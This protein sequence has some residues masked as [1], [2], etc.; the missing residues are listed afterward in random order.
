VGG[1]DS[2]IL[3]RNAKVWTGDAE[4]PGAS[5]VDIAGDRIAWVGDDA[6]ARERMGTGALEIDAAGHTVMPG[7]I[8]SHNHVRLGSGD[9]AVELH[10]ARSADEVWRRIAAW[11]DEHPD[12]PWVEGEGLGYEAAPPGGRLEALVD[13]SRTRGRPAFLTTY[14]AHN[15]ILN[16]TGLARFGITRDSER[17]PF[18]IV[19]KDPSTGD[20]TGVI[21]R[22]AVMGL[23]RAGQA[24]LAAELPGSSADRQY[25]RL[26]HGLDLAVACGITTVVEPQNS[27]DDLPLFERAKRDG[28]LRSRLIGALFHPP[29]TTD[30]EL[31]AFADAARQ[32]E[33]DRLRV[34]PIKLYIDDVAEMHTAAFFEP[35][36][37]DPST[38]G[39]LFYEPD[40]FRDLI[41]KLDARGFQTFTHA[42]G[43]RGIRTVLDALEHARRVNPPRDARHQLV[44]VECP[45]P[46]DVP[47]FAEL[48]AV[49]CMQPRHF[50]PDI[51]ER[52]R[53]DV[54][55]ERAAW[56]APWRSLDRS[57][58]VL[59]FSS[60]WNVAEMEPMI[61]I[62]SAVTRADLE[63]HGGWNVEETVDVPTAVRAYTRGGAY[64]NH[65]E[66]NRGSLTP[67]A[68]ADVVLLSGDLFDPGPAG[69]PGIQVDVT[70]VGGR[71]AHTR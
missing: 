70:I 58:A 39:A 63:G 54:G 28:K 3:I 56:A 57:G 32:F 26:L 42:I 36:A 33:D 1:P 71:I 16:R 51:A 68:Y 49:A 38:A 44:H 2:D 62:H 55:P 19:Q 31:D 29:G 13:E 35:Y 69:I 48:G 22:F 66:T 24:A 61:G 8:D 34:G 43:D 37:T 10:G 40:E 65:C 53:E 59:A 30:D 50:A 18:G 67:G 23:E 52:W 27:L 14:D 60:D 12:A 47:R 20:P 15:A 9:H 45:D 17:V 21:E 64:A 4:R 41:A 25:A 6:E 5:A 46:S 11:L 7:V